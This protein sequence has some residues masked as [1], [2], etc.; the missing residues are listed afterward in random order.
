LG[1]SLTVELSAL[2][3]AVL[4]RIQ[5]PQPTMLQGEKSIAAEAMRGAPAAGIATL[6]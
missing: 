6:A 1:D 4:V 5:V 3:R 2:D